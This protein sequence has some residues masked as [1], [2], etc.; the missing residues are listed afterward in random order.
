MLPPGGPSLPRPDLRTCADKLSAR[1]RPIGPT[2]VAD[3]AVAGEA[4]AGEAF[5]G[6]AVASRHRVQPNTGRI[7]EKYG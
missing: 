1:A 2:A 5:A 6:E 7:V 4:V 3:E